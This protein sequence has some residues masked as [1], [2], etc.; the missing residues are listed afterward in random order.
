MRASMFRAMDSIFPAMKCDLSLLVLQLEDL[1]K[2]SFIQLNGIIVNDA[3]GGMLDGNDYR[4]ID[5]VFPTECG[6]IDRVLD[7]QSLKW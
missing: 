7:V 3:D 6:F 4:A 1:H 2:E 5:M